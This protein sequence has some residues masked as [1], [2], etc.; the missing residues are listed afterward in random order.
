MYTPLLIA[1]Y[2]A[3]LALF[4]L[5]AKRLPILSP[6]AQHR[7]SALD[8]LRGLLATAVVVH[9]FTVYYFWR[10]TGLW[11]TTDSRLINNMGAVPVSLFFMITGYLFARKV[12]RS[13]PLWTQVLVSRLKRI[14]PMYLFSVVLITAI[15]LYQTRAA[16][17]DL[18][19]TLRGMAHWAIFSGVPINGFADTTRINAGVQWTLLYEAIF[20]LCLPVLYC[21]LRRRLALRPVLI[22]LLVLACLWPEYQQHFSGRFSKLF[23]AGIAVAILEDW[24]RAKAFAYAHWRWSALALVLLAAGLA[25]KSYSKVQMLLLAVP[26]ALFVLGNS[27]QGLLEQRG[28]KILGEASFSIYL[29]H[30]SVIYL[31]FSV[32]SA[33][34]FSA[35][36]VLDY[37]LWLPLVLGL[38]S[39]LSVAT[40]WAVERP[41]LIRRSVHR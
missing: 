7:V 12:W 39:T 24:L 22:G 3:S 26:F 2:V 20:Y 35:R 18:G 29:L 38:V 33:F 34:D 10:D 5:L 25:S 30:G 14:F 28:M 6:E 36:G 37:A 31:L 15:A 17:V 9:H 19:A 21:L 23:I 4:C 40:Y 13:D 16:P 11:Q 41:F 1:L 27:L 8:G 32:F